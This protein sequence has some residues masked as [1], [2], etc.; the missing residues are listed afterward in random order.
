MPNPV[1]TSNN[2]PWFDP[3]N[4]HINLV[5]GPT[6]LTV[7][8]R[9]GT[10]HHIGMPPM[11]SYDRVASFSLVTGPFTSIELVVYGKAIPVND[12]DKRRQSKAGVCVVNFF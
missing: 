3:R 4:A 7:A 9:Y 11:V 6:R 10:R 1:A 2:S 8:D 12:D 5:Y